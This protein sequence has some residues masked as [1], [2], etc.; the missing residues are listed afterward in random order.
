MDRPKPQIQTQTIERN[1]GWG[2]PGC[3]LVLVMFIYWWWVC[4]TVIIR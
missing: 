3:L 4:V 1:R 2:K